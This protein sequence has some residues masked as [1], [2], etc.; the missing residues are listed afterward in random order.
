MQNPTSGEH[1]SYQEIWEDDELADD[2]NVLILE[3]NDGTAF[4]AKIGRYILGT[5]N[6][7]VYWKEGDRAV[8]NIGDGERNLPSMDATSWQDWTVRER[9]N[10]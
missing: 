4:V 1:E 8:H 10:T 5:G 7:W 2:T 9:W 6:G 3:K